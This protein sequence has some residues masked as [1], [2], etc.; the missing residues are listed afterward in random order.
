MTRAERY[1]Q[2]KALRD[3][4]LL[5]REISERVGLAKQTV[6]DLLSDPTGEKARERKARYRK[7]CVDCGT[8]TNPNGKAPGGGRCISCNA[9]RSREMSRKWVLDSINEWADL[10]G[11]VPP[12]ATDWNRAHAIAQGQ[13]WRVERYQATGRLWPSVKLA[14]DNFGS[15]RAAI[16]AAGFESF[17][18]GYYGRDGEGICADR[19]DEI[20]ARYGAGESASEIAEDLG[21]C[22]T[23]VRYWL[24]LTGAEIRDLSTAGRLRWARQKEAA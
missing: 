7:P 18:P 10:H 2:V 12:T 13:K 21:V 20:K 14:Q 8:M 23:T 22:E 16:E 1:A 19:K 17:A 11:G 4:G 9:A 15:W 6:H 24:H 3:E 5:L